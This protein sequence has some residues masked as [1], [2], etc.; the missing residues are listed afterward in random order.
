M[1]PR[2]IQP[3][4]PSQW[5]VLLTLYHSLF[6][7]VPPALALSSLYN[8]ATYDNPYQFLMT[9]ALIFNQVPC[10]ISCSLP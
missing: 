9:H 2:A 5:T 10:Q 1:D 7:K 4:E 6:K 3:S 8:S